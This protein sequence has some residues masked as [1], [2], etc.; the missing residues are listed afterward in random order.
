M[1]AQAA[2]FQT[3]TPEITS[4]IPAEADNEFI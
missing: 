1:I 3:I 2:T 4:S